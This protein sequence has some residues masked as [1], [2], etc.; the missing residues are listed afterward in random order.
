MNRASATRHIARFGLVYALLSA[1]ASVGIASAQT[2]APMEAPAML[3]AVDF[4][5]V[6][7]ANLGAPF[8]VDSGR[9]AE[10]K[11]TSAEIRGYAHLMVTSHIPVVDALNAILQHKNITP[12]N[13]LLHGAY[14]AMLS[15]LKADHGTAFDRDYVTG[16]VEYQKGNA[17]L[18][19]Q[20]I[21]NG[22]DPD[23][24]HGH[25][26]HI[27]PNPHC[28]PGQIRPGNG[29]DAG[30][31][32]PGCGRA[33]ARHRIRVVGRV[34]RGPAGSPHGN[35]SSWGTTDDRIRIIGH[36]RSPL[37]DEGRMRRERQSW[38]FHPRAGLPATHG[39]QSIGYGILSLGGCEEH[40]NADRG[41]SP[42]RDVAI[43]KTCRTHPR[44]LRP[45]RRAKSKRSGRT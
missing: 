25:G 18:F 3:N 14:D 5:F 30:L 28:Q 29:T 15:T 27:S 12:S 23:L 21:Q 39:D 16:Q 34:V 41:Q 42:G 19:Q 43:S 26:E 20:E 44:P 37:G 6:G 9:I 17:A 22:S 38:R 7:Q 24:F 32:T 36:L 4:N 33:T 1:A 10:T 31:R 45:V 11:S 40:L 8:Q 35:S 13:T 2:A